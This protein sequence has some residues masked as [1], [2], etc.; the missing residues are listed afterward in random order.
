MLPLCW[1]TCLDH[2]TADPSDLTKYQVPSAP[3]IEMRQGRGLPLSAS[4]I[5]PFRVASGM[6]ANRSRAGSSRIMTTS[7][8]SADLEAGRDEQFPGDLL[9]AHDAGPGAEGVAA[10]PRGH[11]ADGGHPHL[12]RGGPPACRGARDCPGRR[13]R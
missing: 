6:A 11:L 2:V 5:R 1:P 8:R 12:K 10:P 13:A 7:T 9:A 4:R 3:R